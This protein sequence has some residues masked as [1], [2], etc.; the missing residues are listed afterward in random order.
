MPYARLDVSFLRDHFA[1]LEPRARP[2]AIALYVQLVSTSAELLLD[3]RLPSTLVAA[4]GADSGISRGRYARRELASACTSLVQIGLAEHARDGGLTLLRWQDHHSSR[5]DVEQARARATERKRKQRGQPDEP[6]TAP[7]S[8]RDVTAQSQ[9]DESV[10]LARARANTTAAEELL[11]P[12]TPRPA[13]AAHELEPPTASHVRAIVEQ[14]AGADPRSARTV[15]PYAVQLDAHTFETIAARV[16]RRRN[17]DNPVGLLVEL[18]RG[19]VAARQAAAYATAAATSSPVD[20]LEAALRL[21]VPALAG[22]PDDA[23]FAYVDE[24]LDRHSVTADRRPEL[25]NL[26]ADILREART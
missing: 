16:A 2:A 9:R 19:E 10:T 8:Q 24:L 17:V 1:E 14:L 3:G 15:E 13:A 5:T 12:K 6:A 21:H 18:L 26:A 7:M 11:E 22:Q 20:P 23:V 4:G 25:E